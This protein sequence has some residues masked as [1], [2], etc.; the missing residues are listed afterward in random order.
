[1]TESNE[2]LVRKGYAAFSAGDMATLTEVFAPNAVWHAPGNN[3][4]SG[5]YKGR[6][7]VFGFFGKLGE[8]SGG[9]LRVELD[10]VRSEGED[11]VMAHHTGSADRNGKHLDA[12]QTL[13]FTIAGGQA[14]DVV[15]TPDDQAADD[16][17]WV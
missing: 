2:A 6:D 10:S 1:M 4:L 17:F 13:E 3:L 7:A 16:A 15:Q 14:V 12:G 5:E 11:K 8:L 9:T